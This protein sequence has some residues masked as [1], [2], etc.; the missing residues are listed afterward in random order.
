[1][2][3]STSPGEVD[4]AA[5]AALSNRIAEKCGEISVG[6]SN[7]SGLLHAVIHS[8]EELGQ[9]RADLVETFTTLEGDQRKAADASD[10]AD[11]CRD[12]VAKSCR[13]VL[14]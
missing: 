3:G 7:I 12:R 2:N 5:F 4:S 9:K 8:S 13:R 6:S 14:A 1:M 11:S 10:E